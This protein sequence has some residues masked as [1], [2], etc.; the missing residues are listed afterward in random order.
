MILG[1]LVTLGEAQDLGDHPDWTRGPSL[2]PLLSDSS[3]E[4][5]DWNVFV[6]THS[7][8]PIESYCTCRQR[9]WTESGRPTLGLRLSSTLVNRSSPAPYYISLTAVCDDLYGVPDLWRGSWVA[10]E[11]HRGRIRRRVRQGEVRAGG[12]SRVQGRSGESCT[13]DDSTAGSPLQDSLLEERLQRLR[14]TVRRNSSVSEV[15]QFIAAFANTTGILAVYRAFQDEFDEVFGVFALNSP[16]VPAGL[17]LLGGLYALDWLKFMFHDGR[18]ICAG[19]C[20][21]IYW[22]ILR[23]PWQ[24]TVDGAFS[25]FGTFVAVW[26]VC[27][28]REAW[29]P[30]VRRSV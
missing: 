8:S 4:E 18:L 1:F 23:P 19:W 24:G 27:I 9:E 15:D 17:G 10:C 29:S 12:R 13:A 2:D 6:S 11:L 16:I 30:V 25:T 5:G 28:T 14:L 22:F 21:G 26:G 3:L 7:G 20:A